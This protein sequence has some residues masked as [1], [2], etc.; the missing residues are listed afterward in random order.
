[1]SGY[2]GAS[3]QVPVPPHMLSYDD[4][5]AFSSSLMH[6]LLQAHGQNG[7]DVTSQPGY[8]CGLA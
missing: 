6:G 2:L 7:V 3:A 5:H 1:M 4:K 8:L